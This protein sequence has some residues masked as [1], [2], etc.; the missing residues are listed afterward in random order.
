MPAVIVINTLWNYY[1]RSFC[2][3]SDIISSMFIC[4]ALSTPTFTFRLPMVIFK[5]I[6]NKP[7]SN[8]Y[9]RPIRSTVRQQG[10]NIHPT[11]LIL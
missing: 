10:S 8:V 11:V 3:F 5:L 1:V 4:H 9:T 6:A 2:L 7:S